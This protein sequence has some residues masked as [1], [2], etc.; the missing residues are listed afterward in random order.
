[1]LVVAS[2][3]STE[4]GKIVMNESPLL[5][6]GSCGSV[7]TDNTVST[8]GSSFPSDADRQM[9]E[10][11]SLKVDSNEDIVDQREDEESE[12]HMSTDDILFAEISTSKVHQRLYDCSIEKQ[13]QGKE[14]R[15]Q[16]A[17]A[18]IPK[19]SP[20]RKRISAE[21]AKNLFDRLT[22]KSV[23]KVK[24]AHERSQTVEP[25]KKIITAQE[26]D[27][28]F[29]RLYHGKYADGKSVNRAV[30]KTEK[31]RHFSHHAPAR[32]EKRILTQQPCPRPK[33]ISEKE[34]QTLFK[35]LYNQRAPEVKNQNTGCQ[36]ASLD[37]DFEK[38]SLANEARDA[39]LDSNP[40]GEKKLEEVLPE[41]NEV[42]KVYNS[43]LV[44][45]DGIV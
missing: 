33:I 38:K 35:R 41:S 30:V 39:V 6:K 43:S 9:F 5:E 42:E 20:P 13:L 1:M 14:R 7:A 11:G 24:V 21:E 17:R 18:K 8:R 4:T 31:K 10:Q 29:K 44:G 23:A 15:E 2:I 12:C 28:L 19:A 37:S 34:A 26:A 45:Q 25:K 27:D 32:I 36:V 40:K 22:T 16:I 3:S